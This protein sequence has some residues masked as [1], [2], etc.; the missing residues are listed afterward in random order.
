ME[1]PEAWS[2]ETIQI[3]VRK[4]Y[5]CYCFLLPP[6]SGF[7]PGHL[8]KNLRVWL[9]HPIFLA[10]PCAA[11]VVKTTMT[12]SVRLPAKRVEQRSK[13]CASTRLSF[14]TATP[15]G[16]GG[17]S[18]DR[19]HWTKPWFQG[20]DGLPEEWMDHSGWTS[21]IRCGGRCMGSSS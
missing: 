13:W 4:I 17:S 10:R 9:R 20:A 7:S 12:S 6:S 5:H 11:M 1:R 16:R 2:D 3:P 21:C 18:R 14:K 15:E 19:G 8:L